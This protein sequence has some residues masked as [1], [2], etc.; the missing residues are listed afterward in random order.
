MQRPVAVLMD[1]HCPSEVISR[2]IMSLQSTSATVC[3]GNTLAFA[4]DAIANA[5]AITPLSCIVVVSIGE[6]I[7]SVGVG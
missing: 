6:L 3:R 4:K 5:I 2:L 7:A 1:W